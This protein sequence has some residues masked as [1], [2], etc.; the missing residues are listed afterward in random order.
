MDDPDAFFNRHRKRLLHYLDGEAPKYQGEPG[1]L[2]YIEEVLNEWQVLFGGCSLP[3]P[4]SEE[5]T[6]WFA[7]YQLEDLVEYPG[8]ELLDPYEGILMQQLVTVRELLRSGAGL[9]HG[10]YATRPGEEAAP[11]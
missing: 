3:S 4:S 10:F 6:F 9:P 7:L 8:Q 2:Q 11:L 5:R 1:A